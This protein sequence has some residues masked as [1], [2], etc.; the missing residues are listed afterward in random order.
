MRLYYYPRTC[1]LAAHI[2]LE[3]TGLP[4]ERELVS[5]PKRHNRAPAYLAIN[6]KG[7]V[8]ALEIDG[9]VLT[10]T[11]AILTFLGDLQLRRHYSLGP[12]IF[13]AIGRTSG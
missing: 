5:L 3:E 7:S 6:P 13:R 1:A 4:Y 11:H 9:T 2:A 10:E 8:P 12:A